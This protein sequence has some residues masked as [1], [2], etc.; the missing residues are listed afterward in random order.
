MLMKVNE[1]AIIKQ[2][3]ILATLCM[4]LLQLTISPCLYFYIMCLCFRGVIKI[5]TLLFL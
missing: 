5:E 2:K 4:I 3:L 1:N